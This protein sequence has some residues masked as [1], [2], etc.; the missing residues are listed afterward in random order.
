MTKIDKELMKIVSKE[1]PFIVNRDT[2]D[3]WWRDADN[4]IKGVDLDWLAHFSQ[5]DAR[6]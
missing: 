4:F 3:D 6:S 5:R 2:L 1:P